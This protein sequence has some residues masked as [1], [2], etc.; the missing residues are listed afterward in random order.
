M[1]FWG[2]LI[3]QGKEIY[4]KTLVNPDSLLELK[5]LEEDIE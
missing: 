5:K 3:A 4:T 1:D 2:C